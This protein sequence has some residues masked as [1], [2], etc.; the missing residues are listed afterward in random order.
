MNKANMCQLV[1]EISKMKKAENTESDKACASID[2]PT[3]HL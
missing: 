3:C 1:A 2:D